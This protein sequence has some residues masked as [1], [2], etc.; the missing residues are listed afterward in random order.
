MQISPSSPAL[1]V[2]LAIHNLASRVREISHLHPLRA[3]LPW[4]GDWVIIFGLVIGAVQ[5]QSW[6]FD[7]LAI[8]L[9]ATRQHA[10][11]VIVHEGAHFRLSHHRLLNDIFANLF[12]A[13]PIFFCTNSYR[14]HHMLHHR[15]LNTD[16]DPDWARKI[17]RPEWQF[18]QSGGKVL[19][20]LLKVVTTS[21]WHLIKLFV[22]LSG[23][24]RK[25][26]WSDPQNRQWALVK[27]VS[28]GSL[29]LALSFADGWSL[30]LKFWILP[31]VVVFP[32]IERLR[33]ISEHFAVRYEGELSESRNVLCGP[34]EAF[35]FGPHNVR[36]HLN[37]H[38]FPTVP[39]Y[40]LPVL[41]KI[42]ED[43][44]NFTAEAHQNSSYISP[45]SNSVLRD[46]QE[47]GTN[48]SQLVNSSSKN[49][50]GGSI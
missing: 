32:V 25:S 16:Q 42:L 41:Q 50:G 26:T 46:I 49:V 38:L 39:Q 1:R 24:H 35:L 3:N 36:Y 8:F 48:T 14:P 29:I 11:L 19:R 7:V 31:Y 6:F 23:L 43:E 22:Q 13:Y 21:W 5:M 28:Y 33:S 40:N 20:S 12:C 30:F 18:P 44:P 37:H 10:L 34:V 2:D 9:I 27:V 15:H 17:Q 47:F 4:V 45:F